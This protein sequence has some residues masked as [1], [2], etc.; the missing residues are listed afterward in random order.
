MKQ[1]NVYRLLS[2]LGVVLCVKNV[3]YSFF[4]LHHFPQALPRQDHSFCIVVFIFN[5]DS[6][7]LFDG[8]A[9]TSG[10]TDGNYQMQVSITTLL[11]DLLAYSDGTLRSPSILRKKLK[12][13]FPCFFVHFGTIKKVLF[14]SNSYGLCCNQWT[15]LSTPMR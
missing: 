9:N 5:K 12:L 11:T 4:F 7:L 2:N 15:V 13:F 1:P 14:L 6:F 10:V 3:F 8:G